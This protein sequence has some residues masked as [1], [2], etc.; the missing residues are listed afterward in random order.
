M[1]A[2]FIDKKAVCAFTQAGALNK[3]FRR[4]TGRCAS[5]RQLL[6]ICWT[7][8]ATRR[9]YLFGVLRNHFHAFGKIGSFAA[10]LSALGKTAVQYL[11]TAILQ[12]L[13]QQQ[14]L[15]SE[16][17]YTNLPQKVLPA[18][19]CRKTQ[20][21]LAILTDK[22]LTKDEENADVQTSFN[23]VSTE[24][25]LTTARP[26]KRLRPGKAY[27]LTEFQLVLNQECADRQDNQHSFENSPALHRQ[28]QR[29]RCDQAITVT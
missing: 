17:T 13:G 8:T 11:C 6:R 19:W 3:Q 10:S 14:V 23:Q 5:F 24:K 7:D 21:I 4:G 27:Y 18:L 15:N 25:C 26:E 29:L 2:K 1:E 12:R 22:R 20:S 28:S 16:E 9:S